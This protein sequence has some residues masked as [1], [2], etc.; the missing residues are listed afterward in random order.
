MIDEEEPQIESTASYWDDGAALIVTLPPRA[1]LIG[2]VAMHT[3]RSDSER[4]RVCHEEYRISDL[5]RISKVGDWATCEVMALRSPSRE[6][7]IGIATWVGTLAHAKLARLDPARP[8]R[9]AFDSVTPTVFD[10][11]AQAREIVASARDLL[12]DG[13]WTILEQEQTVSRGASVGHIDIVAW[14]ATRGEAVIDLKTGQV[15]GAAWLQVGG[16]LDALGHGDLGGVLHVPRRRTAMRATGAL[17]FR[18]AADLVA[19]WRARWARIE[20]LIEGSELPLPT[21]G[22]HCG[23]C[24]ADCPVRVGGKR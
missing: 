19:A 18:P 11:E 3:A 24:S 6:S 15:Q 1:A 22:A 9:L 10:A 8:S 16:Y 21:P 7:R 4:P 13:G 17:E 2:P 14:S 12:R 23:R 5:T 20:K